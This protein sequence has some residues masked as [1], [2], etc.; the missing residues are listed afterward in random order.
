MRLGA[1]LAAGKLTLLSRSSAAS[2]TTDSEYFFLGWVLFHGEKCLRGHIKTGQRKWP[3]TR[4]FYSSRPVE[5]S[6]FLCANSV[7]HI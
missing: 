6:L 3:G 2:R 7:D 1:R 4:L 5:A